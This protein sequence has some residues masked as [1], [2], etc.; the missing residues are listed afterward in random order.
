MTPDS[1]FAQV[2]EVFPIAGNDTII[3]PGETAYLW[4]DG[5]V[6]YAWTP[7]GSVFT[8]NSSTT[9]VQPSIPTVYV[10]TVTDENGCSDTASVF[11]DLFPPA[12]V[13]ASPD[14]YGFPGDAIEIY[15]QGMGQGNYTW[16]PV[17]FL[18]C[19]NC[20]VSSAYPP[21]TIT[22]TVT[23]VN[24]NGCIARDDV[25]IYFDPILYVPNTFTPDGNNFNPVFK[26]EGGNI[27]D[28]NL[29]IFNRWG[30]LIFESNNFNIGWDG[31]YGG[32]PSP[33]GTYIWVIEYSDSSLIPNRIKG[34][35]NLL[36]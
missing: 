33:D 28:Y 20:Q 12:F 1:V 27:V 23:F 21:E 25:T 11:V 7:A 4:A 18:S 32:L 15:A 26:P 30:E 34:H 29:K 10:V 2:I 31:T 16:S 5:G 17:E 6:T 35:V 9:L 19:A 13:Q 22:Y 8:P 36:R 24:E 3:C 14:Y